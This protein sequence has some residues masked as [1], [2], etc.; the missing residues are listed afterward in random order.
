MSEVTYKNLSIAG[1]AIRPG[2]DQNG[3][4]PTYPQ[5]VDDYYFSLVDS[6]LALGSRRPDRTGT[7]T[8]SSFHA[9]SFIH[10]M[11]TG[12]PILTTKEVNFDVVVKELLWFLSGSGDALRF[13]EETGS[14]IWKAWEDK[15]PVAYGPN[16]RWYQ[17]LDINNNPVEVDQLEDLVQSLIEDPFGRRHIINLWHPGR[18]QSYAL[19]PCHGLVIQFYVEAGD[20]GK[21][22]G[23]SLTVH[24]RSADVFLGLPFNISSYGLLLEL[25]ARAAGLEAHFLTINLGDAH[26]YLDHLEALDEQMGREPME[27]LPKLI[28]GEGA[29]AWEP[30]SVGLSGYAYHPGIRAKVSV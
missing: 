30:V 18:T 29:S 5:Q 12:F 25:V 7:G 19:P 22:E 26:V 14:T 3:D 13:R 6:I 24:Q 10:D 2:L 16:Y 4:L 23:L 1:D 11:R 17:T 27:K 15:G 9:P 8:I 20:D 21:P 28:I